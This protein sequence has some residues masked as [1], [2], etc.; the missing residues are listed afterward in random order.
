MKGF[1][2]E[3]SSKHT[4][5]MPTLGACSPQSHRRVFICVFRGDDGAGDAMRSR[6]GSGGTSPLPERRWERLLLTMALR[7]GR[8]GAGRASGEISP[9]EDRCCSGT[10]CPGCVWGMSPSLQA[11][12]NV[13]IRQRRTEQGGPTSHN[14]QPF[15]PHRYIRPRTPPGRSAPHGRSVYSRAARTNPRGSTR[16]DPRRSR[17]LPR[18]GAPQAAQA[19]AP[20]PTA[21]SAPCLRRDSP[22]PGCAPP[23][24]AP[25]SPP[26]SAVVRPGAPRL[27][28]RLKGPA[29]RAFPP[30]DAAARAPSPAR[31][32]PARRSAGPG[33]RGGGGASGA[34]PAALPWK[35][36]TAAAEG[37]KGRRGG[38]GLRGAAPW[39]RR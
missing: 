36:R 4:Q 33:G 9:R 23:R 38:G 10:D 12:Q 13:E 8:G 1:Q 22:P 29:G 3:R 16:P 6:A 37:H 31:R 30:S 5:E 28:E 26:G 24:P 25:R 39:R 17:R 21:P 35:R 18:R 20:T 19:A 15:R 11:F 27:A 32:S 2:S 7:W 34:P 14:A